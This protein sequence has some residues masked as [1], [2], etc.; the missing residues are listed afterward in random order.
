MNGEAEL[1]RLESQFEHACGRRLLRLFVSDAE[2]PLADAVRSYLFNS[3]LIRRN[4][5]DARASDSPS[6]ILICPHHCEEIPTAAKLI[7]RWIADPNIP[8]DEVRFVR[9]SESMANGGGPACL[10]LRM[11]LEPDD[12]Q[13]LSS[14]NR[15]TTELFDKL[16]AA[17][18]QWYPKSLSFDDLCN[19]AFTAELAH[20]DAVLRT[21][22]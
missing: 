4:L 14:K 17:I 12:V 2:L 11:M 8:I 18:E 13:R 21:I 6:Y 9:L 3:Q 22:D 15:L 20:I 7:S 5:G 1:S 19:S 16:S 10:R